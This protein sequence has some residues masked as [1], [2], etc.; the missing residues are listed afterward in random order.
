[1]LARPRRLINA[2]PASARPIARDFA[3]TSPDERILA[4]SSAALRL[5]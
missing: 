5:S 2:A 3:E 4:K 1:M